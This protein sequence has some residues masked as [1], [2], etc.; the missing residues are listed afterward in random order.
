VCVCV[1]GSACDSVHY[2][3]NVYG[4]CVCGSAWNSQREREIEMERDRDGECERERTLSSLHVQCL[5]AT[6]AVSL[7]MY[8]VQ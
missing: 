1:C 8:S 3:D 2:F 5:L 4:N 6:C 7:Y